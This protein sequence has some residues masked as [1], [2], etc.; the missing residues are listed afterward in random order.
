MKPET[1]LRHERIA[2]A[3]EKATRHLDDDTLDAICVLI[4]SLSSTDIAPVPYEED[5]FVGDSGATTGQRTM[6]E[7]MAANER[8]K[9]CSPT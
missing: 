1:D 2:S 8:K 7:V 4:E 5:R 3:V 6:F 9:Q